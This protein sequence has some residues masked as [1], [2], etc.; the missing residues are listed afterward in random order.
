MSRWVESIPYLSGDEAG[1]LYSP[2]GDWKI[3][4]PLRIG[5]GN[6]EGEIPYHPHLNRNPELSM[7]QR[8]TTIL[9]ST[10]VETIRQPIFGVLLFATAMLMVFN[11]SLAAFT[12]EDDDKLLLDLGL[13]TLLLSGLF[14]AAFSAA[15]VVSREI[16]NKTAITVISKPVSR[17]QFIMAKFAG[18]LVALSLAFY[19]S[20]L[21]FI[22][23]QRHGVLQHTSDPW[24]QPVIF[25]GAGSVLVALIGS[26]FCNYFY[27]LNFPTTVIAILTPLLTLAVIAVGFYDE[28]WTTI[29][30]ASNFVGGQVLLAAY[31]VYLTIIIIAAVAVA[32]STRCGQLVTLLICTVVL[33]VGSISDYAFGQH[34]A[35]SSLAMAAYH[36]IPNLGAFW[37]IDGLMAGTEETAIPFTYLGYATAYAGLIVVAVVSLAVIGFQRRELA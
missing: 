33:A 3:I 12:L 37:V 24:D 21:I 23:A 25:L 28:K 10:V 31:L 4:S 16:E 6:P 27:G 29:P 15:S 26:A 14:L 35:D 18:I 11:V 19:I 13:N 5:T 20:L 22:L 30:F 2:G 36:L 9:S 32:V 17:P 34:A 1:L 7:F 8:F